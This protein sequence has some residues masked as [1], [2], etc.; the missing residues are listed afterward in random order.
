MNLGMLQESDHIL[1][2]SNNIT[3]DLPSSAQAL[4]LRGLLRQQTGL[5]DEAVDYYSKMIELSQNSDMSAQAYNNRGMIYRESGQYENA[6]NDFS[7]SLELVG[8]SAEVH[9]NLGGLYLDN[10]RMSEALSAFSRAIYVNKSYGP[11]YFNRSLVFA[12]MGNEAKAFEDAYQAEKFGMIVD[13]LIIEIT[14]MIETYNE[15]NYGSDN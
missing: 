14:N 13:D 9:N 5:L 12:S 7:Q 15:L 8:E 3:Q 4:L 1:A 11:A 10:N 2:A 6:L